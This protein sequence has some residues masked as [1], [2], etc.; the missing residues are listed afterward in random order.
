MVPPRNHPKAGASGSGPTGKFNV[1]GTK[2]GRIAATGSNLASAPKRRYLISEERILA[3]SNDISEDMCSASRKELV[4]VVKYFRDELDELWRAYVKTTS[5]TAT[6]L[7]D[8]GHKLLN[9]ALKV[10]NR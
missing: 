1:A 8:A 3:I 2:S 4:Q 7:I 10:S 5:D 6:G 9:H